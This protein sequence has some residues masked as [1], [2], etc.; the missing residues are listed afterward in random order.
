MQ[1]HSHLSGFISSSSFTFSYLQNIN[2]YRNATNKAEIDGLGKNNESP[3]ELFFPA[4]VI[5]AA[6]GEVISSLGGHNIDWW[7]RVAA[8]NGSG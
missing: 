5:F 2:I 8:C 7:L 6:V 4:P 3:S 1:S